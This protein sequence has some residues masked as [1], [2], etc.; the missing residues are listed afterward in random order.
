MTSPSVERRR[1]RRHTT[2]QQLLKDPST[3]WTQMRVNNWHGGGVRAVEGCTDTAVWYHPGLPPT[4][5]RGILSRDPWGEFDPQALL[6]TH[7]EHAP[8]QILEWFVRRWTME[9]TLQEACAH[10]GIESQRQWSDL[11]SGEVFLPDGNGGAGEE[12]P[13]SLL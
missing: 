9:V 12:L 1:G 4:A 2:L 6:T 13:E 8:G 11:A 3:R 5:T 7:L 10:L